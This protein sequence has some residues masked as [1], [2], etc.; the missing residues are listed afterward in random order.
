MS[1]KLEIIMFSKTLSPF[2][3]QKPDQREETDDFPC[4]NLKY[5]FLERLLKKPLYAYEHENSGG[6]GGAF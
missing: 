2:T 1:Q 6:G 4:F 5:D 3:K